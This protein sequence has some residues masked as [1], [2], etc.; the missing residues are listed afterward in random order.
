MNNVWDAI[1]RLSNNKEFPN[2]IKVILFN[3]GFDTLLGIA[4]MNETSITQV[5][6]YVNTNGNQSFME[7]I[8]YLSCC[9][10]EEYK[11]SIAN[12]TFTFLPGHKGLILKIGEI[13]AKSTSS[14]EEANESN[15][16]R[17]WNTIEHFGPALPQM[18]KEMIQTALINS[19]TT[20]NLNRYSDVIK[21][22]SIYVYL[23]CG[24][25]CYEVLCSNLAMPAASTIGKFSKKNLIKLAKPLICRYYC[26][27]TR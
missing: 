26:M 25:Q 10:S 19:Q 9:H 23:L 11:R 14:E 27:N 2:C 13:V 24:R 17:L 1:E 21:Y 7:I 6:D 20:P 5:E 4:N 12:K 22:F 16:V 8:E 3:A 15:M 18:L